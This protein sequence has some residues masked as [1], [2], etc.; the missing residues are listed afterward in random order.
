MAQFAGLTKAGYAAKWG[1]RYAPYDFD[2]ADAF[3]QRGLEERT[4][5]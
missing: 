4:A 3:M 1:Y 2:D 5:S